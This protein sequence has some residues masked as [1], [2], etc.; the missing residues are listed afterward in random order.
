MTID[1]KEYR[2]LVDSIEYYRQIIN[3]LQTDVE[4][5]DAQV[6]AMMNLLIHC[7]VLK[8]DDVQ[9][10]TERVMELKI[11]DR[12]QG[13]TATDSNIRS[14]FNKNFIPPKQL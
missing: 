3:D 9:K 11:R 10:Y 14:V 2:Y 4:C 12:Q 6:I 8:Y 5:L 7:G 13:H 1:E